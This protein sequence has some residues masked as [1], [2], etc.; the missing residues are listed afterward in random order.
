M[1]SELIAAGNFFS[2]LCFSENNLCYVIWW[3]Y[4]IRSV[5]K[6]TAELPKYKDCYFT[7]VEK[8]SEHVAI[9]AK[10]LA[11]ILDA[12]GSHHGR[13]LAIKFE[14]FSTIFMRVRKIAKSDY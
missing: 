2:T 12:P 4:A 14:Y 7:G 13:F 5:S 8:L 10:R 3:S 1:N 11:Y 9:V 6:I